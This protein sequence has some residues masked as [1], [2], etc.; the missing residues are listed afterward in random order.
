MCQAFGCSDAHSI[1]ASICSSTRRSAAVSFFG[2]SGNS[3]RD[4]LPVDR[5]IARRI[6]AEPN[7]RAPDAQNADFYVGTDDHGF[8]EKTSDDEHSGF[9]AAVGRATIIA[10][11]P[12]QGLNSGPRGPRAL[13]CELMDLNKLDPVMRLALS[14]IKRAVAGDCGPLVEKTLA[15]YEPTLH[16]CH[17]NVREFVAMHPEHKHVFGFLVAQR[18]AFDDSLVIAHSAV[19]T[20]EGLLVDITPSESEFAYPF[21]RHVGTREEFDLIANEHMVEVPNFLVRELVLEA[22]GDAK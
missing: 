6:N 18:P 16:R 3:S 17:D 10:Q 14:V 7:L 8:F 19:E 9:L 11:R 15:H 22:R 2:I 21:V 13:K 5:H 1:I 12:V 4:F 20:P